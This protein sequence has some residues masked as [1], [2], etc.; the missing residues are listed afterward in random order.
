MNKKTA[1]V[2][3]I[4]L[5]A[6]ALRTSGIGNESYWIDEIASIHFSNENISNILEIQDTHPPLYYFLLHFWIMLLGTSEA[7]TRSLSCLCGVLS[8]ILTFKLAKDLF[9]FKTGAISALFIALSQFQI[10]YSQETRMYTLLGFG[11]VLSMFCFMRCI[12]KFNTVNATFLVFSN[13]LVLYSHVHGAFVVLAQNVCLLVYLLCKHKKVAAKILHWLAVYVTTYIFYLPVALHFLMRTGQ[14]GG[15]GSKPGLID[16]IYVPIRFF[17]HYP[18]TLVQHPK[19]IVILVIVL[20]VFSALVVLVTSF[21]KRLRLGSIKKVYGLLNTFNKER[22]ELIFLVLWAAVALL[23]PFIISQL[24]VPIYTVNYCI[25]ASFPFAILVARIISSL[26]SKIFL[27]PILLLFIS[28]TTYDLFVHYTTNKKYEWRELTKY[29]DDN[30]KPNDVVLV[31]H[32]GLCSDLTFY[33]KRED[34][35]IIQKYYG[36]FS[37]SIDDEYLAMIKSISKRNISLWIVFAYAASSNDTFNHYK[38]LVIGTINE[39]QKL[40]YTKRFKGI[41]LNVFEK[42]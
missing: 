38:P 12:T 7:A 42:N 32:G 41:E 4:I 21:K 9:D 2:I 8:V 14:F 11:A 40:R 19:I 39:S 10:Y 16:L 33:S 13:L 18:K 27:F 28:G 1:V 31:H 35:T 17:Y 23:V 25:G 37:Q 22:F 30:A 5:V 34:I 36:G 20:L 29:I 3:A 6:I 15:A 24:V 26:K